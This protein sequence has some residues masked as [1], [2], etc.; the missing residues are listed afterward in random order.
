MPND[1]RIAERDVAEL[2]ASAQRGRRDRVLGILD[3]VRLG[4]ERVDAPH[5]R[6][7]ALD[8]V[9]D[10]ADRN[11]RPHQENQIESERD[12]VP[13]RDR[14]GDH[15]AAPEPQD[16]NRS[17][18]AHEGE[19]REE[20]APD[21]RQV[22]V[23]PPV[24]GVQAGERLR[25]IRLAPVRLHDP[26]AGQVLLREVGDLR[27]LLLDALEADVDL[28]ADPYHEAGHHDHRD[29][30]HGREARTDPDHQTEGQGTDGHGVHQVHDRRAGYLPD[31]L[32][33]VGGATHQITGAPPIIELR[34]QAKQ[35]REQI[36]A[37]VRFDL[38]AD[39]VQELPHSVPRR[40]GHERGPHQQQGVMDD[41]ILRQ[42]G[43]ESVDG[44]LDD[45]RTE[46]GEHVGYDDQEHAGYQ[47]PPVGAVVG[48]QRMRSLSFLVPGS[49]RALSRRRW[50]QRAGIAVRACRRIHRVRCRPRRGP[51]ECVAAGPGSALTNGLCDRNGPSCLNRRP[52]MRL[53]RRMTCA[54]SS[55]QCSHCS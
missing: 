38:P 17:E 48:Q 13:H 44:Q 2:D 53:Y 36:V 6:R 46:D 4:E 12:V 32:H 30:G 41:S 45:E 35:V 23:P 55:D 50:I 21:A 54:R 16:E 15:L 18:S 27:E 28:P 31:G 51:T 1:A 14:T 39:P 40:A 22:H 24:L 3:Q 9:R 26:Y 7:P 47:A 29:H 25:S 8:L 34:G 42:V 10:P 37:E 19:G 33:V 43:R 52:A 5:R 20:R 49:V 11:H